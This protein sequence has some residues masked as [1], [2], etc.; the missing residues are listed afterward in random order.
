MGKA[1]AANDSRLAM[2]R[3]IDEGARVPVEAAT[4]LRVTRATAVSR[5]D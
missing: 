3:W 1:R 2:D 5:T 4:L